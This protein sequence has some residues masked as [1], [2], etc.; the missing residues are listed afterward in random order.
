M[1]GRDHTTAMHAVN[2]IQAM[3]DY[4]TFDAEVEEWHRMFGK[5]GAR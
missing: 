3:I 2:K 5:T 1:G 4:G